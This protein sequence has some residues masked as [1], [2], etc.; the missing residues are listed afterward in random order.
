MKLTRYSI[1]LAL[2]VL[3]LSGCAVGDKL[4]WHRESA[5]A[6]EVVRAS[7]TTATATLKGRPQHDVAYGACVEAKTR[8]NV[9]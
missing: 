6:S 5:P 3:A 1:P 2:V 9:D 7:C 4:G 8:Q